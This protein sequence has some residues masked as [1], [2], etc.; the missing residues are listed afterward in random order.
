[1]ITDNVK[2]GGVYIYYKSCLTSRVLIISRLNECLIL[3]VKL[4][5]KSVIL[6]TLYRSLSQLTDE[7]DNFLSKLEDNLFYIISN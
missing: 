3:E 7:F 1:M 6:S 5:R 2:K 4:N